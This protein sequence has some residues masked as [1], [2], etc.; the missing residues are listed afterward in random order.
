MPPGQERLCVDFWEVK[1][2]LLLGSLDCVLG[3]LLLE[4]TGQVT[5]LRII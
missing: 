2:I 5:I 4:E 1:G 3:K